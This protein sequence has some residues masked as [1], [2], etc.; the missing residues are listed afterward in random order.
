MSLFLHA[1]GTSSATR[2]AA[3]QANKS[4]DGASVASQMEDRMTYRVLK[5]RRCRDGSLV[6]HVT[7][8]RADVG[9]AVWMDDGH[10]WCAE[11]VRLTRV[12]FRQEHLGN[13][14]TEEQAAAA[15]QKDHEASQCGAG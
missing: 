9:R 6:R 3:L 4:L 14:P 2:S 7:F 12:G 5:A 8:N 10:G 1:F 13:F 11:A 15:I